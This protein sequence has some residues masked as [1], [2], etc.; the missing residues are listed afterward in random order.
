MAK[1]KQYKKELKKV[2]LRKAP[3]AP[4]KKPAK[5]PLKI[6]GQK[7]KMTRNES[8]L[9]YLNS[10]GTEDGYRS[11]GRFGI[12]GGPP[13]YGPLEAA[14]RRSKSIGRSVEARAKWAEE[15]FKGSPAASDIRK[16]EKAEFK[17]RI[18]ADVASM[19]PKRK[20]K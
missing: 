1:P 2:P 6:T 20:K 10:I 13:D 7:N 18:K 16:K 9:H 4:S 17:T 14:T 5:K 15:T 12:K 11:D 3:S 8:N 19:K